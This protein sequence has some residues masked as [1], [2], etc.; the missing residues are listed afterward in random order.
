MILHT[1]HEN[2]LEIRLDCGKGNLLSAD[3]LENLKRL[4]R[5]ASSDPLIH[6]IIITGTGHSFSTGLELSKEPAD[7]SET[8]ECFRTLDAL[9]VD[10]FRFPKPFV[11]ALNGHSVGAGFF[12]QLCSDYVVMADNSRIKMGLPELSLGLTIDPLMAHLARFGFPSDRTLQQHLYSGELFGQVAAIQLGVVDE[13]TPADALL[14]TARE[15]L[16]HLL[17]G[18]STAFGYVKQ[19]LRGETIS[20]MEHSLAE[21]SFQIFRKLLEQKLTDKTN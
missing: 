17:R 13:I 11:A 21:E 4:I 8:L 1:F 14:T 6:G 19:T 10:L 9:L 7:L 16:A 12:I 5:E 20:K 3:S 15:K 2:A 18:T